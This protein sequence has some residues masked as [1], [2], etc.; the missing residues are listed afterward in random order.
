MLDRGYP[1]PLGPPLVVGEQDHLGMLQECLDPDEGQELVVADAGPGAH[2]LDSPNGCPPG[3]SIAH[4]IRADVSGPAQPGVPHGDRHRKRGIEEDSGLALMTECHNG[5]RHETRLAGYGQP[6][7]PGLSARYGSLY[8]PGVARPVGLQ[9]FGQEQDF[10]TTGVRQGFLENR[11]VPCLVGED[12]GYIRTHVEI[13]AAPPG[14]RLDGVQHGP[15]IGN[16]DGA[17]EPR[18]GPG[19]IQLFQRPQQ[20]P[21][22]HRPDKREHQPHPSEVRE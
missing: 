12:I 9:S 6:H 2:A 7:E 15:G 16:H 11:L 20:V 1:C 19:L 4:V 5:I 14:W 18:R 13:Y 21:D 17:E 22:A 10:G 3:G 8:G